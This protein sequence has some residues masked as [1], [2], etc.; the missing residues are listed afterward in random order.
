MMQTARE[1]DGDLTI[2]R[3]AHF[4]TGGA[5]RKRMAPGETPEPTAVDGGHVPRLARLMALAIRF[6]QLV[7]DGQVADYADLARLGHVTRARITQIM[8]LLNLAP[9]IQEAIL[10]LPARI[11]GREI[12]AERNLRPLTRIVSWERQRK[13]WSELRR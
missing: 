11:Q 1:T 2:Q 5:G 3:R 9:S 13:L 6:D 8:N 12:I 4:K 10:F 7:R